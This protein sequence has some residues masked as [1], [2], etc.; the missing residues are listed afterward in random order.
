VIAATWQ[1]TIVASLFV[2]K[3]FGRPIPG[4]IWFFSLFIFA[5]VLLVNLGRTEDIRLMPLIL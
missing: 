4:R 3:G 1:F 2:L 5:G